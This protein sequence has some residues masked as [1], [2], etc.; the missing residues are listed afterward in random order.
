LLPQKIQFELV[1]PE[2]RVLIQE[3]QEV[4]LP[5]VEGY[6]GVLPGHAPLLSSLEIGEIMYRDGSRT[7]FLAIGDGFVEVL[8][9]KVSVLV[10]TA[11]QADEIDLDRA[12]GSLER[13]QERIRKW[14]SH[15][16]FWRARS[17]LQRALT[18][19]Q[20]GRKNH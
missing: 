20:V 17:S 15:L 10:R 4:V 12:R 19:I 6:F 2:R 13:A 18:R 16:D 7:R 8:P 9:E 3:I 1:T 11:E 14:E 5:G